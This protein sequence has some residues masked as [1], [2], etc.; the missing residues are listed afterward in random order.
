MK[1]ICIIKYGHILS[2][3][4][5]INY[6]FVLIDR[7]GT[8]EIPY[9]SYKMSR[10]NSSCELRFNLVNLP[11]KS[12]SSVSDS[13]PSPLFVLPGESEGSSVS[14]PFV[15]Y[16]SEHDYSGRIGQVQVPPVHTVVDSPFVQSP[17][18]FVQS[19]GAFVQSPDT[20]VQSPNGQSSHAV[21]SQFPYTAPV[22][23]PIYETDQSVYTQQQHSML[24]APSPQMFAQSPLTV[25]G[26]PHSFVYTSEDSNDSVVQ[27]VCTAPRDTASQRGQQKTIHRYIIVQPG[28]D[29]EKATADAINDIAE[30]L[31]R[32][33]AEKLARGQT[34][35][36]ETVIEVT[37]I[38]SPADGY[39]SRENFLKNRVSR[40]VAPNVSALSST[41]NRLDLDHRT[42]EKALVGSHGS[43][44]Q[45]SSHSVKHS[46]DSRWYRTPT[47][48]RM[49]DPAYIDSSDSPQS[50]YFN[51]ASEKGFIYKTQHHNTAPC[52]QTASSLLAAASGV[53]DD[54]QTL[55]NTD[56]SQI[57]TGTSI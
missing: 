25:E 23:S 32:E 10:S 42:P 33:A 1:L 19:P 30:S 7:G 20:Y 9:P 38:Q 41:A 35:E 6:L 36:K 15:H 57:H 18:A 2:L 55:N 16:V 49:G 27:S 12:E 29:G 51:G 24:P 53:T 4:K 28:E 43:R 54:S 52:T 22:S 8:K 14:M 37:R 21:S 56:D 31:N 50:C 11:M 26:A 5:S 34:P 3:R 40:P 48:P 44:Q 45:R 17:G 39:F 46:N 13:A 47:P